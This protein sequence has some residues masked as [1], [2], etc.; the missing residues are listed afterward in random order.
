MVYGE[1]RMDLLEWQFKFGPEVPQQVLHHPAATPSTMLR[2]RA[3]KPP[4]GQ[5]HNRVSAIMATSTMA[6][7]CWIWSSCRF[8]AE[9][10]DDLSQILDDKPFTFYN[11]MTVTVSTF[12]TTGLS[13]DSA[14]Q[15]V[16]G[17]TKNIQW[18]D[19]LV[20]TPPLE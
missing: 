1:R 2:R 12:L 15:Y 17:A 4:S 19:Q 9:G 14:V 10:V 11:V 6:T 3:L 13:P 7:H 16:H 8:L 18:H 20:Q 5:V